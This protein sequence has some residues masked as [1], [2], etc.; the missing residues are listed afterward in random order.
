MS[1]RSKRWGF[2]LIE[3]LVVIAIIA[4]LAAILLPVF[5]QAR[6]KARQATCTSNL[7]Q[8]S[9]GFMMYVQDYDE[10][11]NYWNWTT[12][13]KNN[14]S[15]EDFHTIWFDSIYPYVKNSG[16]YA[17]PSATETSTPLNSSVF[18][19]SNSSDPTVL[20]NEGIQPPL[21]NQL[22]SY[23]VNEPLENGAYGGNWAG[24]SS[25]AALQQPAD[26]LLIADMAVPLST[27][28]GWSL[29]SNGQYG[30]ILRVAYSQ[31]NAETWDSPGC[32]TPDPNWDNDSR[33]SG[34]NE[35]GFGDGHVSYR[36]TT[37]TTGDL[38]G[39]H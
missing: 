34:G 21:L 29:C 36:K 26:T 16:V 1:V 17:C 5:A 15:G 25:D 6:A 28:D 31:G 3:L 22:I 32:V 20:Q 13:S 4:I 30:I 11:F 37:Q 8:L 27:S 9:M 38:Y 14:G 10:K 18:G 2:T 35:I 19:W 24:P 23:G 33:H 39:P 12:M 7:K